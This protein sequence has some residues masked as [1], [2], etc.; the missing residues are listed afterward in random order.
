MPDMTRTPIAVFTYN[1]P[2]HTRS[3]L[4][5]LAGCA[6]LDECQVFIFSDGPRHAEHTSE[7]AKVRE[8]IRDWGH[9][10][11]ATIEEQ[12]SNQ[13]LAKSIVNGVT[14][15]CDEYGRVIVLEDDMVVSPR[16]LDY[17]L[18]ALDRYQDEEK[19][20]QI[21][22]YM[23]PVRH[24]QEPDAFFLPITT[25]WGWATWGRA[26]KLFQWD[27]DEAITQLKDPVV[28]FAFDLGGVYSF[29]RMM[30]ECAAGGNDSWGI[31]WWWSV[32]KAQKLILHPR[33]SFVWVGGFDGSGTNSGEDKR[34]M[35]IPMQ[36]TLS[37]PW[38]ESFRFPSDI[39]VD[40]VAYERI[41]KYLR[42]PQISSF[43]TRLK[44]K[45]R[46]LLKKEAYTMK[47][48]IWTKGLLWLDA[49][50]GQAKAARYKNSIIIGSTSEI[51]PEASIEN[52]AGS[53]EHIQ[54]GE[55]TFV[56]GRLITY[57]HG[58]DIKIGDWCYIGVRTEIWSMESIS[59]GNNVL[60]AHDVN[61]HDG[62]AHSQDPVERHRHFKQIIEKGHPLRWEELPGITSAPIIID[63]DVWISFGVTILKGVHIGR[64]SIIAA[65][66]I[67]TQNIPPFSFYKCD[68]RPSIVPLKGKNN[69]GE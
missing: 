42:T 53:K 37:F 58:G 33:Q 63:D 2:D 65:G 18:T 62:T 57:G 47:P 14:K 40:T 66:S 12:A 5:S 38:N 30:D 29:S 43:R 19:L 31:R 46:T 13:G 41:K 25:T 51:G 27:T 35:S 36:K 39:N 45:I 1:R 50:I 32:F 9:V 4:D 64:G 67:V 21:S 60:I 54:I 24:P 56:R 28:R 26:W 6:R 55:H 69:K 61:I 44:R 48:Y 7:V 20:C 34:M 3:M 59:I 11:H 17:M 52:I 49:Q 8:L 15:L 23:F 22:G 10:H 68:I 16:F